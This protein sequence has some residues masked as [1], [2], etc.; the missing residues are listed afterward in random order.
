MKKLVIFALLYTASQACFAGTGGGAVAMI[1]V[2]TSNV[3]F[4][5][6]ASHSG[7]PACSTA[8]NDWALS[9]SSDTGK[10]QYALLLSATAQG[11]AVSIQGT[12]DCSAWGDRETPQQLIV[13]F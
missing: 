9:L 4:F 6:T 12:N 5:T 11:K 10:A 7:K 8:G 3:V 2:Q 13:N 1:I